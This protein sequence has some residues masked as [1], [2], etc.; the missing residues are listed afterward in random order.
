ML[1]KSS[2]TSIEIMKTFS[3]SNENIDVIS[4]FDSII[5][6]IANKLLESECEVIYV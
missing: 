2:L 1:K 5:S 6:L 4:K 3:N